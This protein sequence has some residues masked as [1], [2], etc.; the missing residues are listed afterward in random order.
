MKLLLLPL[1][2]AAFV[3][4]LLVL[5]AIGLGV[6]FLIIATVGRVARLFSRG[7]RTQRS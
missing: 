2:I 7:G 6:A 1:A 3:L 4:V 5:G